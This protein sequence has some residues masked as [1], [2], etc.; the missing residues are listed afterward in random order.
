MNNIERD[1]ISEENRQFKWQMGYTVASSL[2]GF[3][4]GLIVSGIIIFTFFTVI[5]KY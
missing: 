5:P 1:F 2:S 4:A 3:I